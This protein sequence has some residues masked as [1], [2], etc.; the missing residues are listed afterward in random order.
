MGQVYT[1]KNVIT[2]KSNAVLSRPVRAV[3]IPLV[4]SSSQHDKGLQEILNN[5]GYTLVDLLPD[6]SEM[7]YA[8]ENNSQEQGLGILYVLNSLHHL[9][10]TSDGHARDVKLDGSLKAVN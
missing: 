3:L 7:K 2:L 8:N 1:E 9:V 10:S 6:C 4:C 5:L